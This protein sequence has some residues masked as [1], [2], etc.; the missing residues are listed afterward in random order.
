MNI[1]FQP[2]EELRELVAISGEIDGAGFAWR[3]GKTRESALKRR[4]ALLVQL[5]ADLQKGDTK[6]APILAD[7]RVRDGFLKTF[8]ELVESGKDSQR[9]A[10]LLAGLLTFAQ[11]SKGDVRGMALISWAGCSW[12]LGNSDAFHAISQGEPLEVVQ[13][14]SLWQLLDIAFRHGVPSRIW[15][16]SLKA[17]SLEACLIGAA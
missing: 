13:E 5:L 8:G 3:I 15:S 12:L 6:S 4:K 16:D 7:I 1:Q 11:N 14:I 10:D 17:V 2:V 9:V